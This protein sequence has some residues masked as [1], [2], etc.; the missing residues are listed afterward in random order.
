MFS[1]LFALML[2]IVSL[3][4]HKCLNT[5]V[6]PNAGSGFYVWQCYVLRWLNL[7][8]A[9]ILTSHGYQSSSGTFSQEQAY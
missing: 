8:K 9:D 4:Q 6:L 1:K 3:L 2:Y 5:S 7:D